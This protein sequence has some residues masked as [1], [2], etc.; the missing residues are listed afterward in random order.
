LLANRDVEWRVER[1]V[2]GFGNSVG[3]YIINLLN[4]YKR[5]YANT[6]KQAIDGYRKYFM[7]KQEKLSSKFVRDWVRE[8]PQA[9]TGNQNHYTVNFTN[10]QSL[11]I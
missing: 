5:I 1:K 11:G 6:S 3:S 8:V 9:E 2:G 4:N 10:S 7:T